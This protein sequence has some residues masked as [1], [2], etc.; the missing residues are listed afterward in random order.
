VTRHPSLVF[1]ASHVAGAPAGTRRLV[2]SG[3]SAT[4]TYRLRKHQLFWWRGLPARAK[5][6]RLRSSGPTTGKMPVAPWAAAHESGAWRLPV[7]SRPDA[8]PVF[9]SGA[10]LRHARFGKPPA[11]AAAGSAATLAISTGARSG[12]GHWSRSSRTRTKPLQNTE[13]TPNQ[14]IAP[15]TNACSP[16]PTGAPRY[17]DVRESNRGPTG[18]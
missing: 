1:L 13:H 14:P 10:W 2:L 18:W 6:T 5:T 8:S 16:R 17:Q 7:A 12:H 3:V 15:D 9:F 11:G 4:R